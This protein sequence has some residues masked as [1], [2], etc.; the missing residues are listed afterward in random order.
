MSTLNISSSLKKLIG[1]QEG[2]SDAIDETNGFVV[3]NATLLRRLITQKKDEQRATIRA[4]KS[5]SQLQY[6]NTTKQLYQLVA[7]MKKEYQANGKVSTSTVKNVEALRAQI[8]ELKKE[9]NAREATIQ[10]KVDEINHLFQ[11]MLF[12]MQA[13]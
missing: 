6:K 4:A 7:A 8:S 5:Y 12:Y 11:K 13:H 3:K 10:L 2:Y 1:T 9:I